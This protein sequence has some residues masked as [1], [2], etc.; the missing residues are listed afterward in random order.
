MQIKEK[1]P[2]KT[3]QWFMAGLVPLVI[4]GGAIQPYLGYVAVSMMLVMFI[5]TLFRGRFYCGWICAMGAFHERILSL[6]SLKRPMLPVFKAGWFRW[7]LFILMMGLLTFRLIA[8]EGDPRQIGATFVM[9]WSL[10]TGLAVFIG[11][12]WKPRS[13]CSICP[14]A[15]FQGV[16]SPCNYLLQVDSSCKQ[17]GICKKSCPIETNA[18]SFRS[19]GF[20]PGSEC[21]RCGNCVVNCP[22]GALAFQKEPIKGCSILG[23]LGLRNRQLIERQG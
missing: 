17:C 20:V 3:M 10:S 22:K 18:G 14:M 1:Q 13:W 15:T 5:M 11:L 9:M 4:I 8:S 19:Q 23:N 7:L 21:M 12:I 6:I 2:R 16:I